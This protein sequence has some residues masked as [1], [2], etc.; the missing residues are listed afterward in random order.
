MQLKQHLILHR[1]FMGNKEIRNPCNL[2]L[3]FF[4]YGR[5][6]KKMYTLHLSEH[7]KQNIARIT[8]NNKAAA[9]SFVIPCAGFAAWKCQHKSVFPIS[10]DKTT[11]WA[12]V[13]FCGLRHFLQKF[14]FQHH[15]PSQK[16]HSERNK[17][18]FPHSLPSFATRYRS[19][20]IWAALDVGFTQM[21]ELLL[22]GQAEDFH[23]TIHNG[24]VWIYLCPW[25]SN[26]SIYSPILQCHLV[27][28]CT[29]K[30]HQG[31]QCTL[32]ITPRLW[33]LFGTPMAVAV[34][35]NA[36]W[37][38]FIWLTSKAN[39]CLSFLFLTRS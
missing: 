38:P 11:K 32:K 26:A 9:M 3:F 2:L 39:L 19:H 30:Q 5:I 31:T 18:S 15:F 14:L 10:G 22:H 27:Y 36:G 4:K 29:Y 7:E 16:H 35:S 6:S 1:I 21:V 20:L 23:L 37:E 28:V 33:L 13:I 25:N 17:H 24:I 8:W 12:A 34:P